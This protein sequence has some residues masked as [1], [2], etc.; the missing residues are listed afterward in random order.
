MVIYKGSLSKF[1][2]TKNWLVVST[3]QYS[4]T[5]TT[6]WTHWFM[7]WH[8]GSKK[9]LVCVLFTEFSRDAPMYDLNHSLSL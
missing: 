5:M 6:T 2:L 7:V 8:K 3:F 9:I 1:S 4:P